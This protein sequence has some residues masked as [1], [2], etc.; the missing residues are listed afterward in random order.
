M[1]KFLSL[2]PYHKLVLNSFG[3]SRK[4]DRASTLLPEL[5]GFAPLGVLDQKRPEFLFWTWKWGK[6]NGRALYLVISDMKTR[7]E[8]DFCVFWEAENIDLWI[9]YQSRFRPNSMINSLFQ[10]IP[11]NINLMSTAKLEFLFNIQQICPL[12]VRKECVTKSE[13]IVSEFPSWFFV[14]KRQIFN[15]LHWSSGF[16]VR[17]K[18]PFPINRLGSSDLGSVLHDFSIFLFC[19]DPFHVEGCRWNCSIWRE[20]SAKDQKH[21][22]WPILL[23]QKRRNA[24]WIWKIY[25]KVQQKIIRTTRQ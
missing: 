19:E 14:P 15:G 3:A 25:N 8:R 16:F 12:D 5:F 18:H 24:K 13:P 11:I 23:K 6:W 22:N 9:P 10:K 7:V 2:N 21:G 4:F 1:I 17:L 20:E